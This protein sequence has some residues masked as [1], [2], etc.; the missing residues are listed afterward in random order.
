MKNVRSVE[1][2]DGCFSFPDAVGETLKIVTS[3][4]CAIRIECFE[5][6]EGQIQIYCEENLL[7]RPI[8]DNSIALDTRDCSRRDEPARGISLGRPIEGQ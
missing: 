6:R 3:T 5:R 8:A 2:S 7:V 4:G 1:A